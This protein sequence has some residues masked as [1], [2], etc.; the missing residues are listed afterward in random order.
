MLQTLGGLLNIVLSIGSVSQFLDLGLELSPAMD[1]WLEVAREL[2]ST[3]ANCDVGIA[4]E[5]DF[6]EVLE[7][8]GLDDDRVKRKNTARVIEDAAV[9]SN[10]RTLES[11][12]V[13]GRFA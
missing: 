5:H 8:R 1:E 12:S 13:L 7:Q 10:D 11:V 2:E 6:E 9:P 4:C 3:Q